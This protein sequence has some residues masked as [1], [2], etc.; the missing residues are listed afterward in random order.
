MVR[1]RLLF[2]G[3]LLTQLRPFVRPDGD[4]AFGALSVAIDQ[5]IADAGAPPAP[6]T[7]LD[8]IEADVTALRAAVGV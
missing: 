3:E 7:Q 8:R 5:A 6:G 4:P 1:E 2:V